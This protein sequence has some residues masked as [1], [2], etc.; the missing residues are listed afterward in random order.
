MVFDMKLLSHLQPAF[1]RGAS[2]LGSVHRPVRRIEAVRSST[3]AGR[4]TAA[5]PLPHRRGGERDGDPFLR[6]PGVWAVEMSGSPG[7]ITAV[8]VFGYLASPCFS[9]QQYGACC[10][11]FFA[12]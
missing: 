7:K 2:G 1:E 6:M 12:V 9:T 5:V 10:F 3:G 11:P 4:A 8:W